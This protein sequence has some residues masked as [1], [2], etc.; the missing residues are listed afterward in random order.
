MLAEY[1]KELLI[2]VGKEY[3]FDGLKAYDKLVN[4]PKKNKELKE[5]KV[6]PWLGIVDNNKCKG[7]RYCHG[8][9]VQCDKDATD[10]CKMCM[11]SNVPYGRVEDRLKCNLTEYRDPKGKQTLPYINVAEKLGIDIDKANRCCQEL[12]DMNIPDEHLIPRKIQ[13]GRPKKSTA[14]SDTESDT[15]SPKKKRGRPRKAKKKIVTIGDEL[16]D[17]LMKQADDSIALP[18]L[19]PILSNIKQFS[20]QIISE[21]ANLEQ[22][23]IHAEECEVV[24]FKCEGVVYWKDKDHNLYDPDTEDH[25]GLYDPDDHVVTLH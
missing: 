2:I 21:M 4:Q 20:Q 22:H 8:L 6:L 9:H 1:T 13:R 10:L 7:L 23:N 18:D 14:V 12:Y 25:I 3:D 17:N 16:I 11:K 24:E 15:A 19:S 5:I